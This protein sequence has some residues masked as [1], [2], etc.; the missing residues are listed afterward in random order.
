MNLGI[1]SFGFSDEQAAYV[2]SKTK[3]KC[4]IIHS[5]TFKYN[6]AVIEVSLLAI[7]RKIGVYCV[8]SYQVKM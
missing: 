2:M 1:Y 8:T 3:S 5:N 4:F 7:Y 6:P